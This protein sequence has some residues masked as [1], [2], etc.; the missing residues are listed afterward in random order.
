MR[1][2]SRSIGLV[3]FIL[4]AIVLA[5]AARAQ[6]LPAECTN[7]NVTCNFVFTN[8]NSASGSDLS[9]LLLHDDGLHGD[10]AA[11]DGLFGADIA[12]DK[13]AGNYLWNVGNIY[14]WGQLPVLPYCGC[15]STMAGVSRLWTTGPGDVVHFTLDTRNNG[16]SPRSGIACDHGRPT[17][18]PLVVVPDYSELYALPPT[19]PLTRSG[20]VWSGV[21][22]IALT[23]LHSYAFMAAD[24]TVLFTTSYNMSCGCYAGE[25]PIGTFSTTVA[26]S[27]VLFEFDEATG[28]MRTTLLGPTPTLKGSWGALKAIYR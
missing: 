26:N 24:Q 14:S 1:A 20:T 23:G 21:A 27:D 15:V 17:N 2:A 10:G 13:P 28:R 22:T 7:P 16:W 4:A 5:S 19:Y 11:G 6:S 18:A 25:N 12:V 3:A 8:I 9:I